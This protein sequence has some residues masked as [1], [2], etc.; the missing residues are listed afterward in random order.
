MKASFVGKN[1]A[2]RFASRGKYDVHF[3]LSNNLAIILYKDRKRIKIT[4]RIQ[5]HFIIVRINEVTEVEEEE[6][7]KMEKHV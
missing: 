4:K 2:N 7:K 1:N 3:L 5:T 6:L